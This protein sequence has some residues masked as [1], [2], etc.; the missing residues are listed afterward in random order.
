MAIIYSL[1][2]VVSIQASYFVTSG[3]QQ[4]KQRNRGNDL[5]AS[6][7]AN[8]YSIEYKLKS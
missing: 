3:G 1:F 7:A 4:C 6:P 2:Y 5:L 8:F